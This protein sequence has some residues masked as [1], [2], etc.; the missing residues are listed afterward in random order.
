MRGAIVFIACFAVAHACRCANR[1][2][3]LKEQFC[4]SNFVTH[5][6]V[7]KKDVA[8]NLIY[9]D[10]EYEEVYKVDKPKDMPR[11]LW[12]PNEVYTGLEEKYCGVPNLEIGKEYLI[13]GPLVWYYDHVT[14][15]FTQCNLIKNWTEVSEQMKNHKKFNCEIETEEPI[16]YE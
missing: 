1:T 8:G 2:P 13:G 11:N 5:A 7:T 10:L 9:Y 3:P 16:F 12:L 14:M 15:F 4:N 6:K